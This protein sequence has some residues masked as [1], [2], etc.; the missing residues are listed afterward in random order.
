[1]ERYAR[2]VVRNRVAVLLGVLVVTALLVTQLRYVH[3][4]IR[5][6]AQLPD[7]HPYVNVQNRIADLFGGETSV[8]VGILPRQGD[9]FALPVL[10]KIDQITKELLALDGVVSGNLLSLAAE[11]V[12]SIQPTADG[13]D[14]RPYLA[15]MPQTPAEMEALRKEV[16]ADPL[17]AG[18]LVSRDGR[19]AA[20]VADFDDKLTDVQIHGAVRAIV[21]KYADENLEIALGGAPLVRAYIADYTRQMGVLFLIAFVV[22][23]LVHYEAFRTW[24]AVFLPLLTALLSVIWAMGFLGWSREPLDTWSALTPVVILAVAA[25]HAVQ[26]LKRYY[27]EYG[28][29]ASTEEAVVRSLV[30]LGPVMLTAGLIAAAGFASLATFGVSSVRIFGMNLAAGILSALVI[31]MTFIPACRALLPAPRTRETG[32]EHGG[33]VLNAVLQRLSRRCIEHPRQVLAIAGSLVVLGLIGASQVRVDNSFHSWFPAESR[34]RRDDELLNRRLAG[35][36]TLYIL[37]EGSKEGDLEDPAVLRAVGDLEG[38]LTSQP[39]IGASLS[40]FDFVKRMHQVMNPDAPDSFPD[41]RALVAQYLLLYSMS[42]PED[43]NLFADSSHRYGV[44]RAYA[45]SDEADFGDRLFRNLETFARDRFQGLPVQAR[46]AGGALGV[47][48]A[49]NQVV[50]REKVVNVIQVALIILI[51]SSLALRSLV[52]GLLVVTPLAVAAVVNLGVMGFSHTW[53]SA[54]TSTVTAMA[55]SIGADFAVYLIFRIREETRRG[56]ANEQAVQEGLRTAGRAIC[57]VASAVVLGYLVLSLS[58][59]RLWI[60]LGVLTALMMS[61]GAAATLAV[62][63]ALIVLFSPAFLRR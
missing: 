16:L 46:I 62:I 25:G 11:R 10:T 55:I 50:V 15:S 22:I 45:K 37:L 2:F 32:R 51:L 44:L 52:G 13:L 41:R 57:F 26:I 7:S 1:M 6:R 43:L 19:A 47:Q 61:V 60:H 12:K 18:I 24:Q 49:L 21:D 5:R 35:T 48:T 30:A 39:N 4:E 54:G 59:F 3:L 40:L 38:W 8:I 23:G 28:H 17:Y 56:L 9:V 29:T 53:L 58:G 20:I 14:V 27:E 33:R 34:I 31:E 42:G 63:P 36:S